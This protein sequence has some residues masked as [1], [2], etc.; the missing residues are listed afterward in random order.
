MKHIKT[1]NT[2]TCAANTD[3]AKRFFSQT[4]SM[5]SAFRYLL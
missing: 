5:N 2:L 1:K 3:A 4:A